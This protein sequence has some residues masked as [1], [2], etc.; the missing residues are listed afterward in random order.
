MF[1]C[2][3]NVHFDFEL[4]VCCSLCRLRLA[5]GNQTTAICTV[6]GTTVAELQ[7]TSLCLRAGEKMRG[8]KYWSIGSSSSVVAC[9]SRPPRARGEAAGRW[10]GPGEGTVSE[11]GMANCGGRALNPLRNCRNCLGSSFPPPKSVIKDHSE[12]MGSL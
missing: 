10:L 6:P 11:L 7:S 9:H 4:G 2:R 1:C 3:T 8:F 5:P 12:I